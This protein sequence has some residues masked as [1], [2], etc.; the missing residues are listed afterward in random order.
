MSTIDIEKSRN[1]KEIYESLKH[2]FK[3]AKDAKSIIDSNISDWND[4]YDG[5]DENIKKNRSRYVAMEVAKTIE[6][7]KPNITEPFTNSSHP[8]RVSS[9]KNEARSRIIQKYLNSTFTSDFDRVDFMDKFVDIKLREGTVWVKTSWEFKEE[10]VREIVPNATMEE[11]LAR[12]DTPTSI[13]EK[14]N[15]RFTVEYNTTRI[16]RNSPNAIICRNEH[17]F[18]DPDAR[19]REELRF[20]IHRRHMTLSDLKESGKVSDDMLDRLSSAMDNT[21]E[22]SLE[23]SRDA[24]A[25]E[26]G[27]KKNSNTKDKERRKVSILEYYG[28]YDL[29][30]DGIAEPIIAAWA[31]KEDVYLYLEENHLPNDNIPFYNSVYSAVPFSLWGNGLGFFLKQDQ[32]AKSGTIRAIFDNMANANNGQK[33]IRNGSIDSINFKRMVNG[34]KHIFV[35]KEG[36]IEDGAFNNLPNA[37]PFVLGLVDKEI[38]EL[39]GVSSDDISTAGGNTGGIDGG[40]LTIAQQRM[41]GM[42]TSTASCLGKV[43]KDWT[44]MAEVFLE[45][46]QIVALFTDSEQQDIMSFTDSEFI[47]ITFKVATNAQRQIRLQHLNMLMQQSKVLG[48]SIPTEL[49]NELVAE[50]FELFDMYDKAEA[51]RTYAPEPSEQDILVNQLSIQKLQLENQEIEARIEES[52]ARAYNYQANAQKGLIDSQAGAMYKD[53]QTQEKVAK[54]EGHKVNTA[55]EPAKL[56]AEM[57]KLVKNKGL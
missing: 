30:G 40:Q 49:L 57:E 24:K 53:A 6:F 52:K 2:D 7:M 45:N 54:A 28:Y 20:I 23:A 37:V 9:T 34:E 17:V 29:N 5:K 42:V 43:F 18:P 1:K 44:K 3:I 48:E 38:K 16:T 8:I 13:E 21:S 4:L 11:I 50:M 32:K 56:I 51:L 15:G 31:E 41:A 27:F 12:E 33:F 36:L 26:Y 19:N 10:N 39:T 14:D 22:S 46:E 25:E 47:N 55:L 35:N